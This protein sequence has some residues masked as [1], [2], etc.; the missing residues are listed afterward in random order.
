M[1]AALVSYPD[2]AGLPQSGTTEPLG[3]PA[4][5]NRLIASS[6]ADVLVLLESGSL[7][8]PRCIDL[9]IAA[10]DQP[11]RG[12]AGP[13]TNRSWNEQGIFPPGRGTTP[14]VQQAAA[15]ARQRFGT[16][17]RSLD[18][19][20]S[21]ADF[22][23]AV[24]RSVV[25]RIGGADEAYGTGPCWEMDY[26]IRA[27]RAGFAGVWVGAAYVH[28]T[29]MTPRRQADEAGRMEISKR[30]YQDRFCGL[31]LRGE[32]TDYE[33]HCRGE[34]CE[35]FAPESL[36]TLALSPQRS[37][38]TN[39][40]PAPA[41][42]LPRATI[43]AARSGWPMVSCLM[44][45]RGRPDLAG[46]AVKYFLAQ[47]YPNKELVIVEDG[48]PALAGLLPDD[49]RVRLVTSGTTRSI[50][51]MRNQACEIARGEVFVQFDDDDW[52][53]RKRV[54]TQ[55]APIVDGAAD[56]TALRDC[57]MLDLGSWQF[58]RL[59]PVL[60]RRLFVR[61]VH[62]GT[63]AYRRQVWDK[64]AR[65]P[66]R[67]LAEDAAFVDQA[68]R[69]GA[70]LHA[71]S[72]EGIFI[73]VRHETNAWQ[74]RCGADIDPGGWQ[75][76]PEPSLPVDDRAFYADRCPAAP[77]MRPDHDDAVVSCIMPTFDRRTFVAQSI[78]YFL[79]QDYPAKE[80]IIVDDGG[81][82]VVDLVPDH[83]SIVYHRLHQR[84]ILGAKRNLGCQLARGPLI[85]H[86]DD[87][88]W[89]AP[90]RLSV[91]VNLLQETGADVCGACNVAYYDP[92]QGHAWRFDWPRGQRPWVA[93]PSLCFSKSLWARSPFPDIAV[94]E[95]TRFTWSPAV[96]KIADVSDANFFVGIIHPRNTAAKSVHSSYWAPRPV[97]EVERLIGDDL[98]FYRRFVASQVAV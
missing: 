38:S 6:N 91:Q 10:L 55:V 3:P 80:L 28:R 42:S 76:I 61:D 11:R 23:Y 97:E 20:Y 16:A 5:F 69:R 35:H 36:I 64:M 49:S 54:S 89:V 45:T 67:S 47:D 8:G 68:V 34:A 85:A 37:S 57:I 13:S 63:L 32:R 24:R 70:R 31:R 58:W 65:Y 9:L 86:W 88:D 96:R 60:H 17:A 81:D 27:A 66:D 46:Q 33:A 25:D 14:P 18:Q 92:A 29:P 83:P 74:L 21:L 4:C 44:P 79:R 75:L 62:G 41:I 43:S 22:C 82:S 12:L 93:G 84:M 30:L 95:D 71:L 98:S 73:Y 26:N 48:T 78:S 40:L 19:L 53:G 1:A 7:V 2:L 50:G 52:H 59:D 51:A 90:N 77:T 56:V 94:G 15:V 39:L 87:D 72:A